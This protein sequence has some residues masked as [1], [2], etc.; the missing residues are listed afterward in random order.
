MIPFA[1]T[2]VDV[3]GVRPESAV[4]PDGAGYPGGDP[5]PVP[6]KLNDEP[7]RATIT[8]ATGRG[9]TA[10]SREGHATMASYVLRM[11]PFDLLPWDDVVDLTTGERYPVAEV[12]QSVTTGAPWGNAL[13]H[14]IATLTAATG[15]PQTG[16]DA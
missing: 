10:A 12:S 4:D 15:L 2:T 9:L 6:A 5:P 16:A 13:D 3:Y 1:T 8:R 14:T 7:I 11:D